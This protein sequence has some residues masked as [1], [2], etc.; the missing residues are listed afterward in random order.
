M[1]R[2][3]SGRLSKI[4]VTVSLLLLGACASNEARVSQF[5]DV[6]E[7]GATYTSSVTSLLDASFTSAIE[8]D[9]H[10]LIRARELNRDEDFLTS[11]LLDHDQTTAEREAVLDQ[12]R[13]QTRLLERYFAA[14]SLLANRADGSATAEATSGLTD[15]AE[16]LAGELGE[17]S[18]K[19]AD[20]TIG[21]KPISDF[22]VG[23]SSLV[24]DGYQRRALDNLL[25]AT[26]EPVRGALD[27]HQAALTA[28]R[29]QMQDERKLM[30]EWTRTNL[31]VRPYVGEGEL[32]KDWEANRLEWLMD[33]GDIP[34]VDQA[35]AASKKLGQAFEK[36]L[37][38]DADGPPFKLLIRDL[39]GLAKVAKQLV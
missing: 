25:E 11:T 39:K 28:I 16:K 4:I 26:A 2:Q 15:A 31:I 12:I 29:E 22:V 8:T 18:S 5:N 20:A 3:S 32:P 7:A 9:N 33:K 6:A 19:I 23:L 38:P 27:V 1:L 14:L 24:I 10:V 35:V 13:K 36:L 17:L 37:N 30:A 34:E 21:E